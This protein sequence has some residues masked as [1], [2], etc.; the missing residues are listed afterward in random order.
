MAKRKAV[1][2][3]TNRKTPKR[4][5]EPA[6]L[7][8]FEELRQSGAVLGSAPRAFRAI[9]DDLQRRLKQSPKAVAAEILDVLLVTDMELLLRNKLQLDWLLERHDAALRN[10]MPLVPDSAT[11]LI[12]RLEGQQRALLELLELRG[13][14]LHTLELAR[15]KEGPDD[16]SGNN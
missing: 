15:G 13:R 12:K 6:W 8:A 5:P 1:K 2:N 4:S 10:D 14:V 3:P 16:G 11:P 9:K 7:K